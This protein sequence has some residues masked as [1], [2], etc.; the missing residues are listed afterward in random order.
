MYYGAD[1]VYI[2]GKNIEG[3][4]TMPAVINKQCIVNNPLIHSIVIPEN[5][6]QVQTL[7]ICNCEALTKVQWNAIECQVTSYG[8]SGV[9][10]NCPNITEFIFGDGVKHIP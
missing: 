8:D 6:S 1:K 4:V 5:A 10:V 9:F 2:D 3:E 7:A